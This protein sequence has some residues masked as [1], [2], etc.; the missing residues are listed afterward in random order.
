MMLLLP[1]RCLALAALEMLMRQRQ[2]VTESHCAARR[3]AAMRWCAAR[4]EAYER[5]RL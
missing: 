1:Q 3:H 5:L 2:M 4:D